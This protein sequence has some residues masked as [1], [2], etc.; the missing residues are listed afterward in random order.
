MQGQFLNRLIEKSEVAGNL[1]YQK[2]MY[3]LSKPE[4]IF[5]VDEFFKDDVFSS[6]KFRE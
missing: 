3:R 2:I 6:F 5:S 4:L 1:S